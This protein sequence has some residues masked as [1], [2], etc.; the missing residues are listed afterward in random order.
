MGSAGIQ[1]DWSAV[2]DKYRID[3]RAFHAYAAE[4][5]L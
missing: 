4:G 5:L 2:A 3:R 1:C